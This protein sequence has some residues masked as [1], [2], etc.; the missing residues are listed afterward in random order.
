MKKEIWKDIPKFNGRYQ[1]SNMGNVRG[2]KGL[3]STYIGNT[4]YLRFKAYFPREVGVKRITFN[5][6]IHRVVCELFHKNEFN[7]SDVNHIDSNKLNNCESNLE[8]NTHSEN[9][10]HHYRNFPKP[11][12]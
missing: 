2:V 6:S 11:C 9:L 7:K 1:V 5:Y 4:G 12:K 10:L 8:W 3:I